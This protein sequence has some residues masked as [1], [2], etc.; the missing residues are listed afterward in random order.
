M[1]PQDLES[2]LEA[3]RRGLDRL[4]Q[5]AGS[6]GE[7]REG[8]GVDAAYQELLT[9]LEE[10]GVAEEELRQ[11]NEELASAR[12]AVEAE[13]R[14]Y[15]D[16][17]ES[18]PD[19]YLVTDPAGVILEANRTAAAL[20]GVRADLLRGKPIA[21]FVEPGR[22]KVFHGTLERL[23]AADKLDQWQVR[24]RPRHGEAFAASV[25]VAADRV[26]DGRIFRMRWMLRDVSERIRM[27]E[28]LRRSEARYRQL[29]EV[30]PDAIFV[31]VDGRSVFVN[32]AT[33]RLLGLERPEDL[34][35]R[36]AME[37]VH[38]DDRD[39]A[40]DVLRRIL[41]QGQ[42]EPFS[43]W[44]LLRPDGA[45]VYVEAAAARIE[46]DGRPAIQGAARD[47][48]DRK[49]A[50]V[51]LENA[52][53]FPAEN[54]HPVL[55]LGADGTVMFANAS[56]TRLLEAAGCAAGGRAPEPWR[57]AAA[58]ALETGETGVRSAEHEGRVFAIVVV[59]VAEAGYVNLYGHD[60]TALKRAQEELRAARDQLEDQVAERTEDLA[61]TI[62]A[63]QAEVDLR[64][65]AEEQLRES[66]EML[67][68]M[69]SSIHL[70]VVHLDRDM[71][72][73]RVN[74]T[75]ADGC[76][77]PVEFFAGKNHFDLYPHEENEA[78]FCRVV[79]TGEP[80]TVF[81]KPFVF[82]DGPDREVTYWDWTVAAVH[83][84]EGEVSG[85]VFT[86]LD[87]TEN[88]R[89][90]QGLLAER[91]RLYDVLN[92]I[93]AFVYLRDPSYRIRFA[94]RQFEE[95]FGPA[96]GRSCFEVL[97]GRSEPC[98]RC[99]STEVLEGGGAHTYEMTFINDRT[100]ELHDHAFPDVDGSPLVL[101]LGVDI[102]ERR[103]LEAEIAEASRL[104]RQRIGQDLH[105]TLGQQLTGI[106]FQSKALA[107]KLTRRSDKE[108]EDA[109]QIADLV[110][111]AIDQAR[112][113]ARGLCPVELQAEGLMTALDEFATHVRK[114]YGVACV[115][116]CTEPVLIPD[117][118]V[119]THVYQIA[120]EAVTNALRH[121]DPKKVSIRLAGAD[122]VVTLDVLDD[123]LGIAE[124]ASE[125]SGMGL[126]IMKHRAAVIGGALRIESRPGHGATV[127]CTFRLPPV[128][129]SDE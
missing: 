72:F 35:G 68:R 8:G 47:I 54:P 102:T 96:D 124:D 41:E 71:N 51:A 17:F 113:L 82:P 116:E 73:V 76:G 46:Y 105:D 103:R 12:A 6:R 89:H 91:Q 3:F 49:R 7:H 80:Y 129:S 122:G 92:M 39:R 13:R 94:N 52:A 59:P 56:A 60:V 42:A 37:L 98:P 61:R 45:T 74:R 15:Q 90:R 121:G 106:A 5:V 65:Q 63:L 88:E 24:L 26:P 112:S 21:V 32:Q 27:E 67:E 50:E 114:V 34:L 18:T 2:K 43:E 11:Q 119:A 108:A 84:A 111:Q 107:R 58:K 29:A 69:F 81:A 104:E 36:P 55:R 126:R 95:T 20:L 4:H 87:V 86:L 33:V 10:L 101:R 70:G 38:P 64:Q 77:R 78:I 83:D 9:A 99:L 100:Y 30:S 19:G 44:R 28:A 48:T 40:A 1:K 14:R 66:H 97:H 93:P 110:N 123:G 22:L 115:F 125:D 57:E 118:T 53:R 79:E 16:L 31:L 120:R 23:V 117:N 62:D 75:Y 128:G 85:V 25:S 109:Q 127:T